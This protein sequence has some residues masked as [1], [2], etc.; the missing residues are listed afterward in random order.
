MAESFGY[1]PR[2]LH[3]WVNRFNEHGFDGLKDGAK[4]GRNSRVGDGV[5]GELSL[6][7]RT[8]P[9]AFDYDQNLW[10]GKLV[11]HH[12]KERYG[13]DLGVRQCQRLL[14]GLGFRLRQPRAV[15][16]KADPEEEEEFKKTGNR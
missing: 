7:L 5:K 16:A 1:S 13:V 3:H 10:D 12:L 8:T 15:L 9:R 6:D 4:T 14:H 11:S 2:S